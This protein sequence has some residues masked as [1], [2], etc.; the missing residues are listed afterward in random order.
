MIIKYKEFWI[1]WPDAENGE[2]L[3]REQHGFDPEEPR[4]AIEVIEKKAYND[5]KKCIAVLVE[6]CIERK[7]ETE[8]RE[9]KLTKARAALKSL[10]GLCL[11]APELL[12]TERVLRIIDEALDKLGDT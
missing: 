12:T 5:Q 9:A 4:V 7:L 3:T 10:E 11:G 8:D 1:G 6:K 2:V